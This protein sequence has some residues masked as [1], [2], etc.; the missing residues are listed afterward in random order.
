MVKSTGNSCLYHE[1]G[2][3]HERLRKKE[4]EAL[5]YARGEGRRS[6]A[7]VLTSAQKRKQTLAN[8]K[9]SREMDEDKSES[10]EGEEEQ[11]DDAE[12]EEDGEGKSVAWW[13]RS[14]QHEYV[15]DKGA[16]LKF[17]N[18]SI[19][20]P[21]RDSNLGG[22]MEL[23][24]G[25]D[26]VP[27]EEKEEKSGEDVV[28]EGKGPA[29]VPAAPV[30]APVPSSVPAPAVKTFDNFKPA[31]KTLV[32]GSSSK[33]SSSNIK[34]DSTLID[35]YEEGWTFRNCLVG[36]LK[37]KCR[38]LPKPNSNKPDTSLEWDLTQQTFVV[39][40][41]CFRLPTSTF[42]KNRDCGL[43]APV[44]WKQSAGDKPQWQPTV[45]RPI[46]KDNCKPGEDYIQINFPGT[47]LNYASKIKFEWHSGSREC[48]PRWFV[49][50]HT[51]SSTLDPKAPI[52]DATQKST[53]DSCEK[54]LM[55][56][57]FDLIH[58]ANRY[59]DLHVTKASRKI[60]VDE[61]LD[62]NFRTAAFSKR[63][64]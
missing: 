48:G 38:L 14:F 47:D 46:L 37:V 27:V 44:E 40:L 30:P 49:I 53:A 21:T 54:A 60:L 28:T 15:M 13:D 10:E 22:E 59:F 9:R 3:Y 64:E 43:K 58:K 8:K 5:M 4:E 51:L 11:E 25:K 50:L 1:R 33:S 20:N 34:D 18:Q 52:C 41:H 56:F 19:T 16:L 62:R 36:I 7:P 12:G 26:P 23:S 29:P 61:Y 2:L 63:F 39:C 57:L 31:A 32:Q 55:G 35:A 24:A 42:K 17:L 45:A 6:P